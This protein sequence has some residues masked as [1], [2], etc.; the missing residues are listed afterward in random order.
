MTRPTTTA[1]ALRDSLR[2]RLARLAA[3]AAVSAAAV[4]AITAPAKA[5]VTIDDV[6]VEGDT[7]ALTFMFDHGCGI[8]PTV[9][10]RVRLPDGVEVLATAQPDGWNAS[11][12]NESV[13]W[14]GPPIAHE[15]P[16]SFT[17]TTTRFGHAGETVWFPAVQQ[18]EQGESAWIETD[19]AGGYPAPFVVLD[20]ASAANA[21]PATAAP[22]GGGSGAS[23]GQIAVVVTAAAFA[24]AA[25]AATAGA[26]R[27]RWSSEWQVPAAEGGLQAGGEAGP[28]PGD[29]QDAEDHE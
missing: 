25:T 4:V 10:L 5:H 6:T 16:A 21:A 24:A 19:D 12:D 22:E 8:S 20:A 23:L 26:R 27:R 14:T 28:D 9:G 17:V 11:S 29:L 7:I 15:Q 2:R 18:C 13:S 1:P 3:A